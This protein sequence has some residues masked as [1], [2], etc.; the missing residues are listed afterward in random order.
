MKQLFALVITLFALNASAQTFDPNAPF[1]KDKN[2]PTFSITSTTGKEVTNKSIPKYRYNLILIFSPDCPHCE[3]EAEELSK[4]A[5]KF[6]NVLF[7]W[8]SFRDMPAIKN[9]AVKYKLEGKANVIVG[10]DGDFTLPTFFRPR[11]T[12]FV[13]LY[14]N[15]KFVKAWEQGVEVAELMKL[16]GVK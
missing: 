6:T 3:H 12:P 10:R 9:F 15:G 4:N 13:A 2:F 5:A 11:M 7:I 8:D 14:D 16:I 1:M